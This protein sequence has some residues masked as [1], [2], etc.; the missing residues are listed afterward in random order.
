MATPQVSAHGLPGA[1]TTHDGQPGIPQALREKGNLDGKQPFP[2]PRAD[3]PNL[4]SPA[5]KLFGVVPR[6]EH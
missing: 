1:T 2:R 6:E 5:Q 4:C 3:G